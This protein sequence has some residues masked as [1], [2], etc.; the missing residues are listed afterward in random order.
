MKGYDGIK[1]YLPIVHIRS[2]HN[3]SMPDNVTVFAICFQNVIIDLQGRSLC[4]SFKKFT[5]NSVKK[6]LSFTLLPKD[7]Y[8]EPILEI[9]SN[10]NKIYSLVQTNL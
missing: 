8:S 3:T 2:A 9:E 5:P 1:Q 10:N 4:P 7:C 6:V